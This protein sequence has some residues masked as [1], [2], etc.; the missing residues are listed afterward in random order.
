MSKYEKGDELSV[1]PSL[2]G[3]HVPYAHYRQGKLIGM[4]MAEAGFD[5]ERDRG[6][7]M[8]CLSDRNEQGRQTISGTFR[9]NSP[10]TSTSAVSTGAATPAYRDGWERIF[11]TR[12][13]V[14]APS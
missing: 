7:E 4:G 14:E 9:T 3:L 2:C 11:A 6:R 12:K 5:P 10:G 13:K 1:G 8:I